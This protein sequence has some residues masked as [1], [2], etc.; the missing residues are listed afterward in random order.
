MSLKLLQK[1]Q[2]AEATDDLIGNKVD[3]KIAKFQKIHTKINQRSLQINIIKE[4][5]KKDMYLQKKDK[6]VLM[7]WNWSSIIMEYKK[8]ARK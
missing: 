2:S 8:I 7:N 3:N 5:L 4:Y 1:K 6:K